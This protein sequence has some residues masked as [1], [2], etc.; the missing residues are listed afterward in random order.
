VIAANNLR[1]LA[2]QPV[3]LF[4]TLA[5]PFLVIL[6]VGSALAGNQNTIRV[7]VA[8]HAHD[9]L[10]TQLVAALRGANALSIQSYGSDSSLDLAV[11]RGQV[12]AGVVVPDG[13]GPTLERGGRPTVGFVDTPD[14]RRAATARSL[15]TGIVAQQTSALQAANFSRRFTGRPLAAETG[16]A[17]KLI[18]SIPAPTVSHVVVAKPS[19][20]Q[21]GFQYTAPSNLVLFVIITSLTGS[22][23]LIETRT[24]GITTR[25]F[26]L[27]VGRPA[28]ILGELLGRFLIALTQAAIILFFSAIA[29]GVSW[30][31]APA[32]LAITLSVCVFGAALGMLVGFTARNMSQAVS[33]G[34]PLGIVL[35]MLGGCMWPLW[36][37]PR[38]VRQVG[39]VTPNAWAMDA[40][41]K[42]ID[43]G[44]GLTA[45]LG[46]VAVIGA[47]AAGILLLSGVAVRRSTVR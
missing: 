43:D 42:T 3:M 44:A 8:S 37:V 10:A 6:V 17:G 11:R 27:P 2:R 21:L 31:S 14:A 35:G 45:V 23:A 28:I 32:V 7:G 12:D 47:F 34:P 15:L 16:R 40:Y 36:I 13:Y 39:H 22:A 24:R 9:A 25:L 20:D 18:E 26:A 19:N 38:I 29:F 30:G 41:V 33:F 1:R 5:L 46:E 4:T